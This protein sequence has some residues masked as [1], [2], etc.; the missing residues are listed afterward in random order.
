MTKKI[1]PIAIQEF[2]SVETNCLGFAIGYTAEVKES[3]S[4]FNLNSNLSIDE[5]FISKLIDL[6]YDISNLRKLENLEDAK[7]YEYIFK[8]IGFNW[9]SAMVFDYDSFK[10][11]PKLVAD[12]HVV[13]REPDGTWVHK[14][15]WKDIPCII[16]DSDWVEIEEEFG[17]KFVLFAL[18]N[19]PEEE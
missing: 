14:P 17:K 3:H 18:S 16:K 4:C 1:R 8:I 12:Y 7:S 15:G 13:R 9:V 11:V 10:Y 6:G 19:S 2:P 5:A